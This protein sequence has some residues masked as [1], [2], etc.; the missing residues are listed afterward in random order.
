MPVITIQSP[1]D[2]SSGRLRLLDEIK[3]N[4]SAADLSHFKF[5][6]AFAKVG[7]L[8]RI[9]PHVDLWRQNGKSIDAIF[10][11]DEK[12]TSYQALDFAL[13]NFDQVLIAKVGQGAFNPTFHPKIYLFE[14]ANRCIAY[15][16]SNNM[17]LGGM[18]T[19]AESF[20]KIEVLLP[21]EQ[22]QRDDI[23]RT[24]AETLAVCLPLTQNLL[25]DLH[26]AQL[27][28]D[29]QQM[30][31]IRATARIGQQNPGIINQINFPNYN[32]VPP[33]P[34]PAGLATQRQ[35]TPAPQNP[36]APVN[37]GI[38]NNANTQALVIQIIPHHNGEIFL[39]KIAVNQN[40]SFLGW[41]F[42]GLTRPKKASNPS[43]P[44]RTPDPI[45]NIF[46][47]NQ[48]GA[49][50][51]NIANHNLNMVYYTAKSEIRITVPPDVVQNT[52]DYS[53]MV[54]RES[55]LHGVDYDIY[56]YPPNE[57]NFNHY[58]NRCNQTMPSGG[59]PVS[60]RFGWI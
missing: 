16:G 40:P 53:I 32:V 41:P 27:V 50:I 6:T 38:L 9:K 60:R 3:N 2:Q 22:Q 44:Q 18:E 28:I 1:L 24:W 34:L 43:Y 31:H 8:L 54:L 14:G 46:V 30:R 4:L 59:K 23:Y 15:I 11:I 26:N 55:A 13:S 56:I 17:T 39:S 29:E 36:A 45:V 58:F 47:F 33:S 52:P 5:V 10:G 51:V 21:A 7:P 35:R 25:T 12:G 57:A 49:N 48:Q 42:T 20:V 37:I 19:N